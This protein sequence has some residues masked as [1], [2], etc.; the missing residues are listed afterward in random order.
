MVNNAGVLKTANPL[1]ENAEECFEYEHNINVLG[2]LR[3]AQAF[4]GILE[5]NDEAA[6]V[7]LNSLAS[8]KN[9]HDFT[10]YSATKAAAYSIT[11]GLK[12]SFKDKGIHVVSVHPGPIETDMAKDA[13]FEGM[14]D[15]V[16]TVSQSIVEALEKEE[17]H[18]FPDKMAKDFEQAYQSYAK[19]I[20]EADFSE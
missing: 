5:K 1:A 4:A 18:A 6:F 15:S 9:F 20:V 11:Q 16:D 19:A 8:I 7:Q 10:T 14:G 2:L 13:G 12:D 17:F 3:L